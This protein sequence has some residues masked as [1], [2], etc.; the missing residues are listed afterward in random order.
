[1]RIR[2]ELQQINQ[3]TRKL[4]MVHMAL[5][6]R[7]D[8]DILYV[9]RKE[10]GRVLTSIK[11]SVDSS[12]QQLADYIKNCGGRLIIVTRNNTD[13]TSINRKQKWEEKQVYGHFK[14]QTNKILHKKSWIWLREKWIVSDCS[15]K[16]RHNES[17]KARI[18]KTQQ[19]DWR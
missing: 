14:W 13:I 1:M 3:R 4:M 12:I 2:E 7:G 18:E 19:I 16:R 5:D 10:G 15:G 9:S 8:V 11:D 6:R 17:V